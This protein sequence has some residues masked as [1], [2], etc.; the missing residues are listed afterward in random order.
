M[1]ET[2]IPTKDCRNFYYSTMNLIFRQ[3]SNYFP[4][5]C[6][7]LKLIKSFE[8]F[9]KQHPGRISQIVHFAENAFKLLW[10]SYL[11]ATPE[12]HTVCIESSQSKGSYTN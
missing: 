7:I 1:R 5:V 9:R 3:T 12:H 2:A 4:L 10:S 6:Q 11:E 8:D